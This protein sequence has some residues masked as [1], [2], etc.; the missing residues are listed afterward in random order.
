M[1]AYYISADGANSVFVNVGSCILFYVVTAG[2]S[3][4]VS[5]FIS[6]P[7]GS[8]GVLVTVVPF[9]NVAKRIIV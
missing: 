5:V 1:S 9:A 7:L 3:V 8:K 4:P 6:S 2:R